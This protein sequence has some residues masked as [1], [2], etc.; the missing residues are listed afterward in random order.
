MYENAYDI[1]AVGM[2]YFFLILILYILLRLVQHSVK[3]FKTVQQIKQKVR[4]VSPGYLEVVSPE[5]LS[6]TKYPLK[7]ENTIG[8]AKRC[9][10]SV[11]LNTLA[12]VHAFLFEKKDG[13]YLADYGSSIGVLLNGE[14]IIKKKDELL[15]TG[16]TLEMGELVMVLHLAGEEEEEA[17]A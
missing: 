2:R 6:G 11:Q 1:V 16:D 10:I 15:Y 12:P 3:E 14:R 5:E 9:D 7:R 8:R 17:D 13:L 4:S